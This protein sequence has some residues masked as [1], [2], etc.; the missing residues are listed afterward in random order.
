MITK[1]MLIIDIL[2]QGDPDKLAQILQDSGMHCLHCLLAHGET[3]E[4]AA[5]VHGIDVD[6]LMKKLNSAVEA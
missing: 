6:K 3:L 4:E 5:A 2:K 1:D